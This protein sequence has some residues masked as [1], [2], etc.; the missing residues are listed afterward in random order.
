MNIGVQR[1][2]YI[3]VLGLLWYNLS[4][5]IAGS[6]GR[7]IFSFLGKFHTVFHSGCTS[8]N[9]HEQRTGVPCSPQLLQYL[10]FVDLLKIAILP[11]VRWYLIVVLIC[12]SLMISDIE[13]LFICLLAICGSSLERCL[14]RSFAHF[15]I[16]LFGFLV[17]SFATS[18]IFH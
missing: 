14:F 16:G 13:H 7:S 3:R 5:G 2:F 8:F 11:G 1:F 9:S 4:S 10:L 17:L 6:K 15:L 12:I 18:A